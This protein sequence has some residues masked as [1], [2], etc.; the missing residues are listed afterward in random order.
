MRDL[1]TGA[2]ALTC[3]VPDPYR[4]EDSQYAWGALLDDGDAGVV[5]FAATDIVPRTMRT[6]VRAWSK[7][8][9]WAEAEIVAEV[10]LPDTDDPRFAYA[11]QTLAARFA[12]GIPLARDAAIIWGTVV[13]WRNGARHLA[14]RAG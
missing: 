2:A 7:G 11:E 8:F 12:D 5:I 10:L 13:A 4:L 6:T 14:A 3:A 9:G 1:F